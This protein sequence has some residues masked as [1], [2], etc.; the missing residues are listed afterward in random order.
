MLMVSTLPTLQQKEEKCHPFGI[1][2]VLLSTHQHPVMPVMCE[3]GL[4]FT[5]RTV[6]GESIVFDIFNSAS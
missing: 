2:I 1:S 3:A 5:T 6:S 4:L